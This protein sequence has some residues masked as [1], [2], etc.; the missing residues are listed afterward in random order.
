MVDGPKTL[1][2]AVKYFKEQETCIRYLAAKRWPNGLQC[3]DAMRRFAAL[4]ALL[5][6][7]PLIGK[8]TWRQPPRVRVNP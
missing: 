1:F 3:L 8:P 7:V 5:A 4:V 2:E 6:W